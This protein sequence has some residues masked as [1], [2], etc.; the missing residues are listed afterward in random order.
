MLPLLDDDE[1]KKALWQCAIMEMVKGSQ[2]VLINREDWQGAIQNIQMHKLVV[3][4]SMAS[5]NGT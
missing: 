3:D 5:D 2:L 4:K 1:V